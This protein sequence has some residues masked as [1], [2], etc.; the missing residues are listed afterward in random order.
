[1]GQVRERGEVEGERSSE[2][3]I[4]EGHMHDIVYHKGYDTSDL[5]LVTLLLLGD[6][7]LS[8]GSPM[9]HSRTGSG[10]ERWRVTAMA[11]LT[12]NRYDGQGGGVRGK[13]GIEVQ[14]V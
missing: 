13:E 5:I 9:L 10:V 12:E 14:Q 6:Q 1:M 7:S 3:G 11:K 4:R 2:S 8:A